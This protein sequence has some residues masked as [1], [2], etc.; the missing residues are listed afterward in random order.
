MDI[1]KHKAIIIAIAVILILAVVAFVIFRRPN[2]RLINSDGRT[3]VQ[4]F[5]VPEGFER[6]LAPEGSF[7]RFLQELPLLP[8]GALVHYYDGSVKLNSKHEAVLDY[9]LPG[10]DLEQCADVVMHLYAEYLYSQGRYDEI[11]FHFVNGFYCDFATWAQG[12][13]PNVNGEE[14]TWLQS[15]Q[16]DCSRESFENYLRI[17]Y[18]YSSP[19][20]VVIVVDM[21]VNKSTGEKRFMLLQGNMPS[22]QAHIIKNIFEAELSPWFSDSFPQGKLVLATW[23]CSLDN[24]KRFS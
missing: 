3:V 11:G 13:R 15:A 24:I 12:K 21:A 5:N 18:A 4:R 19:G 10:I 1:R 16:P 6:V 14:V 20:H 9:D 22:Q 2:A 8:D 17:V 7:G 23:E